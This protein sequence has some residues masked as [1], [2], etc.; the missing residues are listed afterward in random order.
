MPP[1]VSPFVLLEKEFEA[2]GSGEVIQEVETP[3]MGLW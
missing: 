3:V 2:G 1:P